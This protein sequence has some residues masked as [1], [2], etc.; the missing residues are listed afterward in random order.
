M[1][2]ELEV[3]PDALGDLAGLRLLSAQREGR[4]RSHAL[5]IVWHDSPEHTL[6]DQGLTV[7]EWRDRWWL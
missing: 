6:L 3:D 1:Q 2:L 5:K 7:A 4:S